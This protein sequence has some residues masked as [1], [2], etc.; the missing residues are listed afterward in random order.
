MKHCKYCGNDLPIEAFDIRRASKDGRSFKCKTCS[1]AYNKQR[2]QENPAPVK[3]RAIRWA[4]ENPERRVEIRTASADR[5][6]EENRAKGREY[7][8]RMRRED[9]TR[10]RLVGR[11][12]AKLRRERLLSIEGTVSL[13]EI[14]ALLL[15]AG[16]LCVYCSRPRSLTIDHF[17][18]VVHGGAGSIENLIPCCKSCNSS[19]S[20]RDGADWLHKWQGVVGLARAVMFLEGQPDWATRV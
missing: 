2:Y 7:G 15:R 3:E 8:R 4:A 18:P 6:A 9:P 20:A 14:S 17:N 11:L 10:A 12:Y 13:E 5:H 19:K 1:R 16:G